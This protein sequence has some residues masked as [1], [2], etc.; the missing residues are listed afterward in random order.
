MYYISGM[1]L[2]DDMNQMYSLFENL[3]LVIRYVEVGSLYSN[4]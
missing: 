2:G 3:Y 4:F 1:A